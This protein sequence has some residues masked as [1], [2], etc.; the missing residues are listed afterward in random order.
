VSAIDKNVLS[1]EEYKLENQNLSIYPNP[2]KDK[3]SIYSDSTVEKVLVY[4]IFGKLVYKSSKDS[5][6]LTVDISNFSKGIYLVKVFS[7]GFSKTKKI[8]KE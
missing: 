1:A 2:A 3:I 6:N 7:G 4:N 8:V 5:K